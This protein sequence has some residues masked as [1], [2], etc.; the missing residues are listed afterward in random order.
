METLKEICLAD[1]VS[2]TI[3]YLASQGSS[4]H[5]LNQGIIE[6]RPSA[7]WPARAACSAYSTT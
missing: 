5:L 7:I 1:L 3:S 6:D 2:W 4:Q